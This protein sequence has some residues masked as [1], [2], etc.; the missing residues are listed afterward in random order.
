M[1]K[2]QDHIA[3]GIPKTKHT[4]GGQHKQ[5]VIP[6]KQSSI[7]AEHR[8]SSQH[9]AFASDDLSVIFIKLFVQW[10]FKGYYVYF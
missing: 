3:N 8:G 6:S 4:S 10:I 2:D 7:Q 5:V 1:Q 9:S